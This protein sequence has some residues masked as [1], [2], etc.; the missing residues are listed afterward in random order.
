M[1]VERFDHPEGE[2]VCFGLAD[3]PEVLGRP[4]RVIDDQTGESRDELITAL[5]L[6]GNGV[7]E[8]YVD[9]T[10]GQSDGGAS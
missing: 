2:S 6:E 10:V 4:I 3:A 1:A 5:W 8:I 9:T 7:L